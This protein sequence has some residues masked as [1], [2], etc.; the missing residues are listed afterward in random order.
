MRKDEHMNV[1][2][3]RGSDAA[4]GMVSG[5]VHELYVISY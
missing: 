3:E 2:I 5:H 1:Q 4:I